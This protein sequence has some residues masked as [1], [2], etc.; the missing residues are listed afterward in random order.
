MRDNLEQVAEE[1]R[2]ELARQD[3][4]RE[5]ALLLSRSVIR[6]SAL[7]IRAIH[8]EEFP[9]AE[10]RLAEAR[11]AVGR[12]DEIGRACPLFQATG[13]TTDA[14]KEYAEAC[15]TFALLRGRPLPR[16]EELRV[17]VAPYLN[18]LGEA[19]TELRRSILDALRVER[20]EQCEGLLEAMQSIYDFLVTVDYP[21]ALTGGLRRTTDNVR[22]VLENTRGDLT[23]AFR[24]HRLQE[25][26]RRLE[27]RLL[28]PPP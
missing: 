9:D 26:L 22:R 25:D 20:L 8:R 3:R 15:L 10:E 24:Q 16:P 5:E 19:A 7:A 13:F 1:I 17:P 4:L 11:E 2:A 18:A 14:Q 6:L 12:L 27:E 28:H 21:E 23:T